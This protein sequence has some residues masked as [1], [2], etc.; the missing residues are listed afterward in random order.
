[1]NEVAGRFSAGYGVRPQSVAPFME[2]HGLTT[3]ALL[4]DT[5]FA[6]S[7][8]RD[9]EELTAADRPAYERVMDIIIGAASDPSLLGGSIHLLYVGRKGQGD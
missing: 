6:A 5:A 7:Q 9:L 1:L 8:V 2:R 3:L 4:A